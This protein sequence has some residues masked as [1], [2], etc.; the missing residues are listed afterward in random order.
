MFACEHE[1]VTPD[2]LCLG[3]SLTGGYLPMAAAI[4]STDVYS[5]FLGSTFSGRSFLHGHTYGGNQLAAAAA[6]ASLDLLIEHQAQIPER[7]EDLSRMLSRIEGLPHVASTRQLGMIAA[8]EFTTS[9][10]ECV[11]YPM[12]T[13]VAAQIC[14]AALSRGVW[15]RPL[16][17]VLVIMPPL[18]ISLEE[19]E[20][21]GTVIFD[22]IEQVTRELSEDD[23]PLAPQ[24]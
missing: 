21:L 18:S 5:A 22:S 14:R 20:F 1:D 7:V 10:G 6:L 23:T 9:P 3:K 17:D 8:V 24:S 13:L 4:A 11:A 16:R 2:I 15:L 12:E 19:L